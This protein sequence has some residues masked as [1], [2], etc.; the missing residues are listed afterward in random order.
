MK[1]PSLQDPRLDDFLFKWEIFCRICMN[2]E[3]FWDW[4]FG[5]TLISEANFI[6]WLGQEKYYSYFD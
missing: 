1:T 2:K 3:T 4:F 6:A 5:R